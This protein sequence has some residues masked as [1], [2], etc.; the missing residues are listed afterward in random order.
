MWKR[1]QEFG[2]STPALIDFNVFFLCKISTENK[3]VAFFKIDAK[4]TDKTSYDMK[5]VLGSF[6]Q[7]Q[8]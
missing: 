4:V 6:Y 3:H 1:E 7:T 2:Y 5:C 8:Y